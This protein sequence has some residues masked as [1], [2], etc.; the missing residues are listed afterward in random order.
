MHRHHT[1]GGSLWSPRL[2]V[3]GMTPQSL[4]SHGPSVS[5]GRLPFPTSSLADLISIATPTSPSLWSSIVS[6]SLAEHILTLFLVSFN[7][8]F[9]RHSWRMDYTFTASAGQRRALRIRPELPMGSGDTSLWGKKVVSIL[10]IKSF[11]RNFLFYFP[12]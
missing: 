9:H 7:H 11:S 8:F 4:P 5:L 12:K 3:A 6:P 10:L 2:S 1:L